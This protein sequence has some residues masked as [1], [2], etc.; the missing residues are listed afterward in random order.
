MLNLIIEA[1]F[2][3]NPVNSN[4]DELIRSTVEIFFLNL[5]GLSISWKALNGL[6]KQLLREG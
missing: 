2:P 4:L 5:E 3:Q 1:N 6:L